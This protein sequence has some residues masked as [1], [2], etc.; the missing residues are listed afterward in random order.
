MKLPEVQELLSR[1]VQVTMSGMDQSYSS[2][3]HRRGFLVL[4][5]HGRGGVERLNAVDLRVQ[6]GPDLEA[7]L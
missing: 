6:L 1:A 2:R 7:P 5:D 4:P 3:A